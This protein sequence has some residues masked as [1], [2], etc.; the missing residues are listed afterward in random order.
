VLKGGGKLTSETESAPATFRRVH[1]PQDAAQST[2][3]QSPP[4]RTP[5]PSP[6]ARGPCAGKNSSSFLHLI[7]VLGEGEAAEEGAGLRPGGATGTEER[8]DLPDLRQNDDREG[9]GPGG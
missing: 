8:P 1:H 5:H 9:L 3:Y 6:R 2:P 7:V 4:A